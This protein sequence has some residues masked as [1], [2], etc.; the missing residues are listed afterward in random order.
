MKPTEETHSTPSPR[1]ECIQKP[2]GARILALLIDLFAE[3]HGVIIK[4]TIESKD[5]R[6]LELTT[7]QPF[8]DSSRNM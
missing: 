6:V 7:G 8:P 2:D 3:Q 4:Y 1:E 5:G